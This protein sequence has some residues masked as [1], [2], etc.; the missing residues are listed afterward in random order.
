MIRYRLGT[1]LNEIHI[2]DVMPSKVTISG[3]HIYV[4]N[5]PFV[6]R[7]DHSSHAGIQ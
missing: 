1:Y 4:S 6:S 7:R 5:D 3:D 2:C